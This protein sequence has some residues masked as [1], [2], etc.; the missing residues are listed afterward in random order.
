MVP[1]LDQRTEEELKQQIGRLAAA[2]TPEW[3]YNRE[4]PDMGSVLANL[5]AGL[6]GESI[7]CYN[8]MPQR[9]RLAFLDAL[10]ME[11]FP[12]RFAEGYLVF[13]L[14]GSDMPET[15]AVAGTGVAAEGGDGSLIRFETLEDVYVSAAAVELIRDRGDG[16]WYVGF[17]RCPNRGVISLLFSLEQ[18]AGSGE[19]GTAWSYRSPEGWRPLPVEDLTDGLSHSGMVRFVC[20]SEWQQF[21]LGGQEGYWV[22][23]CRG[24]DHPFPGGDVRVYLNAAAVRATT[25]G[26]VGNLPPGGP[27][28]LTRTVGYVAGAANPDVLIGGT[29]AEKPEQ[30]AI[31]GSARIR[32]QFRAV[33][34]GDFERLVYEICPDV[35]RVK[36]FSGYEGGGSRKAGCVTV[37]ILQRDFREGRRYFYKLREIVT[38]YLNTHAEGLLGVGG[39]LF[40]TQPVAVRV[41]VQCELCVDSYRMVQGI[42]SK[43]KETLARFLDPEWGNHDGHGWELGDVPEYGQIKSCLMELPGVC[44]LE[45]LRVA[46]EMETAEG[47]REA[48]WEQL[49]RCPWILP[50]PGNCSVTV[51]VRQGG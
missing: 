1:A 42:S 10:G 26:T 35:L 34:P 13:S 21:P 2:Y 19:A 16:A 39:R 22:R 48:L 12:A 25:P 20:M 4:H 3:R 33:T 28:K 23:I 29:E 27:Y 15:V 44:S 47:V 43:A 8:Q 7:G 5:F 40:V 17:D 11:A 51:T 38:E 37:V 32:H 41:H 18:W 14:A 24:T 46:Y 30:A 36:C 6:M 49:K 9:N 31:R 45:F 50:E